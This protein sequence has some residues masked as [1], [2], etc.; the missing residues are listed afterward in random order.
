MTT[1]NSGSSTG[2]L[3]QA[4]AGDVQALVRQELRSVRDEMTGAARTS[5]RG[6]AMLGAAGLLGALAA[7]S[8][9]TLVIRVL[10][11]ILPRPVSALVATAL[12]G[13]GAGLLGAAG[14]AELRRAIAEASRET[15]ADVRE[16]VSAARSA[17]SDATGGTPPTP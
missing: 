8:F 3:L 13:T 5:G 1:P 17:A 10:D 4:L 7:G 15:L 12:F 9:G 16:D 11:R 14:I 6:A 2:E